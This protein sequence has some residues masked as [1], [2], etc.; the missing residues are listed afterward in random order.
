MVKA[1]K[2]N[3]P[4]EVRDNYLYAKAIGKF[5]PSLARN[6]VR[7][8]VERARSHN[9]KRVLCDLTPL[10]GFNEGD[11]PFM[12]RF[13]LLLEACSTCTQPV[14]E[15]PRTDSATRQGARRMLAGG[16]ISPARMSRNSIQNRFDGVK[17][18]T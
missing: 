17:I 18:P 11:I 15:M 13:E 3:V 1:M 6:F 12:T 5:D 16:L 4:F 9:L 8:F 14:S 10:T 2:P 7:E